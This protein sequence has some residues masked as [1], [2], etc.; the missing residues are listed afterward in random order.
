MTH[1]S[2]TAPTTPASPHAPQVLADL[3][4]ALQGNV[5]VLMAGNLVV[6]LVAGWMFRDAAPPRAGWRAENLPPSMRPD[7]DA[8]D[9]KCSVVLF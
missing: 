2:A 1:P 3:A 8:W 7:P 5:Q 9:G 4:N 6:A